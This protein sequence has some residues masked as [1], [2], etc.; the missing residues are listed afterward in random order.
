MWCGA[1]EDNETWSVTELPKGKRAIGSKWIY[2]LKLKSDGST[3]R[4]KAR[5]VARDTIKLKG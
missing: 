4:Y 2:K 1:L 3:E 5:L